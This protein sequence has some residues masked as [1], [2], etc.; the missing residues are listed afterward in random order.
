MDGEESLL[1]RHQ[2]NRT[3]VSVA[4]NRME[5]LIRGN[6]FNG[7]AVTS[8]VVPMT[9]GIALD[10]VE[11]TIRGQPKSKS[12]FIFSQLANACNL[13]NISQAKLSEHNINA[14]VGFGNSFFLAVKT[15]LKI[16]ILKDGLIPAKG[17]QSVA[18]TVV[19][20]L[21]GIFNISKVLVIQFI[22]PMISSTKPRITNHLAN[23]FLNGKTI[24]SQYFKSVKTP[25][26][27]YTTKYFPK[28]ERGGTFVPHPIIEQLTGCGAFRPGLS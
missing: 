10:V 24:L 28:K 15:K 13:S 2:N 22:I 1:H 26:S 20:T 21:T 3:I 4:P 5:N 11:I 25:F 27:R 14:F 18:P 6:L 7:G 8:F 9:I 17:A 12:V 23:S 16:A 19:V